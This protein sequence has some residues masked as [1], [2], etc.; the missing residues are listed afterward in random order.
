MFLWRTLPNTIDYIIVT[1]SFN[2]DFSIYSCYIA[3]IPSQTRSVFLIIPVS[4][5]AEYPLLSHLI[6][7]DTYNY[8]LNI[9]ISI[10]K[11]IFEGKGLPLFVFFT[12]S[13]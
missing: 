3:P 9:C 10:I 8:K 2:F 13:I 7:V 11:F 4:I 6:L 1:F 12:P 5:W